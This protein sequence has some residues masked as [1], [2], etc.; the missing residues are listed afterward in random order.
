VCCLT[1]WTL[2]CPD[3]AKPSRGDAEQLEGSLLQRGVGSGNH[4]DGRR[5]R[6]QHGDGGQVA[7]QGAEAVDGLAGVAVLAAG[8]AKSL[9]ERVAGM[10]RGGAPCLGGLRS[11]SANSIGTS[12]WGMCHLR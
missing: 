10:Y 5:G 9:G 6:G 12:A 8:L 1:R 11:S 3:Y 7:E 4:L 2:W